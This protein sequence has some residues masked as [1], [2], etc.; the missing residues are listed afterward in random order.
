MIKN[1]IFDFGDVFIDLDKK[2]PISFF[3]RFDIMEFDDTMHQWNMDYEKGKLSTTA[4]MDRYLEKF[5][6]LNP[7]SFT[8]AWNSMIQYFPQSR[9]D[10]ILELSQNKKYRLF[11]I[12]NTNPL[13]IEKVIKNMGESRYIQFKAAFEKFYL[14]YELHMRKPDVTIFKYIMEQNNLKARETLFVDDVA[15]NTSAA[16]SLGM[17]TWNIK[18]G[19][20]EVTDLFEHRSDLFWYIY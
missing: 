14:S 19:K 2:A 16:E 3:S 13:H 4:F 10:W 1:I 20:E 9:L 5:P 15:S 11:L 18:P 12:S 8:T 6:R 7:I 17:K